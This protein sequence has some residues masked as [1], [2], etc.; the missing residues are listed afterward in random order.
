[1][2]EV[3]N[4]GGARAR[5]RLDGARSARARSRCCSRASRRSQRR[6]AASRGCLALPVRI[7]V[8]SRSLAD[9]V[10]ERLVAHAG[11]ALAG[12]QVQTLHALALEVLER[13]GDVAP[14]SEALFPVLVRRLAAEEP[15]LRERARR[16]RRRLRRGRGG[17]GGPAR[18]GLRRGQRR[19][20]ARRARRPDAAT[21]RRWRARWPSC[22]WRGAA[23]R[24]MQASGVGHRALLLRRGAGRAC[25]ATPTRRSPRARRL[26]PRLRRRDRP[27]RRADRGARALP[28]RAAVL[29]DEPPDPAAPGVADAGRPLH[30][31][32]CARACSA[33]RRSASSRLRPRTGW[34]ARVRRGRAP[35]AEVRELA[36]RV[37]VR[38]R[39]GTP[40]ERIGVV[41]RDLSGHRAA[42]R[43]H[44]GRLGIPF[45]GASPGGA[46]PL[47]RRA[48]ALDVLLRERAALP[49]GPLARRRR[50]RFGAGSARARCADAVFGACATS[51]R[52]NPTASS[53]AVVVV[54][55]R[56]TCEQLERMAAS[57]IVGEQLAACEAL[58]LRGL[59]WQPDCAVVAPLLRELEA[60][61]G[62]AP[63]P[64]LRSSSTSSRCCC[65]VASRA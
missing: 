42:L 31:S 49:R 4:A 32:A 8:P 61:R 33:W 35:D 39:R 1:M 53:C 58:L 21:P 57:G 6:R 62:S 30:A 64:A 47:A 65:S 5:R 41:A 37:R 60:L 26:R 18:R 2:A 29:I 17:G 11:R 12:V 15:L 9:H 28:T 7:V 3:V 56:K 55:A 23:S 44:F 51:R 13:A 40:P 20:R 38:A 54:A 27:A 52:T 36:A 63:A 59:D 14:A 34:R 46:G 16:A 10:G 45:S 50:A 25:C 48:G 22:A 43:L 24:R 19:G